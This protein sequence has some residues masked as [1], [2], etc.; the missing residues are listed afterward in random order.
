[1]Y[2]RTCLSVNVSDFQIFIILINKGTFFFLPIFQSCEYK[3]VTND[4]FPRSWKT[5][6][7]TFWSNGDK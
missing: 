3:L 2:V 6:I 7:Y 1:M 4:L 5:Q